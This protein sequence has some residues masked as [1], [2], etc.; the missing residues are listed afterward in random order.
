MPDDL[1]LP[2]PGFVPDQKTTPGFVPDAGARDLLSQSFSTGLDTSP[3]FFSRLNSHIQS[4]GQDIGDIGRHRKGRIEESLQRGREG[5][6]L[7]GQTPIETVGQVATEAAT[8]VLETGFAFLQSITPD[9]INQTA[10]KVGGALDLKEILP[11]SVKIGIEDG[12]QTFDDLV[13][14]GI[15]KFNKFE[16]EHPREAADIKSAAFILDVI[17]GLKGGKKVVKGAEVIAPEVRQAIKE[18]PQQFAKS[19]DDF[20]SSR[21]LPT[22]DDV[23]GLA[24]DALIQARE[25]QVLPTFGE[26]RAGITPA[27][28]KRISGK[29]E[30]LQRYTDQAQAGLLDDTASPPLSL[31]V[32]DAEKAVGMIKKN[33]RQA[34]SEIGKFRKK[35]ITMKVP[36]QEVQSVISTF[37]EGLETIGLRVGKN[38]RIVPSKGRTTSASKADMAKLQEFRDDLVTLK[39]DASLQRVID[40]RNKVQN[41]IKFGKRANVLTDSV[42]S[43]GK[44]IRSGLADINARAIGPGQA[45]YLER[46]S[47]LMDFFDEWER[48]TSKGR[49]TETL[50]KRVFSE[51]PRKAKE[52]FDFIKEQSGVDLVDSVSFARLATEFIG[53]Q[54]MKGLLEQ[55]ITKAG[56]TAANILTKGNASIAKSGIEAIGAGIDVVQ[57][58]VPSLEKAAETAKKLLDA[59]K[60]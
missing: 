51:R 46:Y 38:R 35:T 23:G 12:G 18:V 28:K 11:E 9:F 49:S 45:K 19:L 43:F 21:G 3:G 55:E 42:D 52:L 4:L 32:E 20:R 60:R 7:E 6:I 48:A 39:G 31:A 54:R 58:K 29:T 2:T 33:L 57:G 17:I 50:L 59:S 24:S 56:L 5:T 15:D 16:A 22:V 37:D 47:E 8:G 10:Q 1:T 25:T 36:T 40:V 44:R 34:G 13:S 27:I 26:R 53:D 14:G 41:E 30:Q